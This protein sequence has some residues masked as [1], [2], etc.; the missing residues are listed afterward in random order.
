MFDSFLCIN[1]NKDDVIQS[2]TCFVL[3]RACSS[4]SV[5]QLQSNMKSLI[6]VEYNLVY[7]SAVFTTTAAILTF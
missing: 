3:V 2:T 4:V 1:N 7:E 5:R 6:A